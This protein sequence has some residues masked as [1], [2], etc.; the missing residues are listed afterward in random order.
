MIPQNSIQFAK[1]TRY[2]FAAACLLLAT[3]FSQTTASAQRSNNSVVP[4]VGERA[5][6]FSLQDFNGDKFTLTTLTKTKGILLWFTNLCEGCQSEIPEVLKL[7][8]L[9]EKKG[10]DVVAVSVLGEDRETVE[11]V[12]REY[13]VAFRFLY[14]PAGEATARYSGKYV[15][16]TCPLKNIFVIERGGKIA[17]ASHLPGTDQQELTN[18]LDKVTDGM[19]R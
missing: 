10:I 13:N 3:I 12:M 8:S 11:D 15:E 2:Y 6:N 1:F 16:G 9:Y 17:F 5:P 19:K 4:K 7:K 18:Q 14:D